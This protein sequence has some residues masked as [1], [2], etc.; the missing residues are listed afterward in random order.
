[1]IEICD[2]LVKNIGVDLDGNNSLK[3][4]IERVKLYKSVIQS[5]E[6]YKKDI[7]SR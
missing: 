7:D 5:N 6:D 2:E 4:M 3:G 1:M